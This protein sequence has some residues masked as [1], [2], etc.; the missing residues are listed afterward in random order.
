MTD[1]VVCVCVCVCVCKCVCMCVCMYVACTYVVS[2]GNP[3]HRP[4]AKL[5]SLMAGSAYS[6]HSLC[7][8][9]LHTSEA[10]LTSISV[11]CLGSDI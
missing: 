5:G 9:I 6:R 8:R 7:T 1:S 10:P 11:W 3:T 4:S 2:S